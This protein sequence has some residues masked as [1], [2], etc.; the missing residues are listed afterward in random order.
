MKKDFI[1]QKNSEILEESMV[2]IV[3]AKMKVLSFTMRI[4]FAILLISILSSP[5]QT[6]A[7]T[8]QG[9]SNTNSLNSGLVGYWTFDGKNMTNATATDSSGNGNHG[10]LTNLTS[11]ST[12]FIGKIGKGIT[13]NGATGVSYVL[14]PYNASLDVATSGGA[15]AMWFKNYRSVETGDIVRTYYR[16]QYHPNT[17][18]TNGIHFGVG[19]VSGTNVPLKLR[20]MYGTGANVSVTAT[21]I[22]LLVNKWYHG[23]ATWDGTTVRLYLDGVEVATSSQTGV[24]SWGY[25]VGGAIGAS[26]SGSG[27]SLPCS[28]AVDDVRVYNRYI[29]S[30]EVQA[31]YKLGGGTSVAKPQTPA[32]QNIGIN[33]GLVGYWTFDGKNMTNAT[34]T[35]SS[36]NGNNGTLTNMTATSSKA[37]GKIGQALTFNGNTQ[38]VL[39]STSTTYNN[40]S[41]F[42]ISAWI[43]PQG[44]GGNNAG[45]IIDKTDNTTPSTGWSFQLNDPTNRRFQF[46]IACSS[47]GSI[48]RITSNQSLKLNTWTHV[49]AK[50]DGTTSSNSIRLYVNGVEEQSYFLSQ[51]CA[52]SKLSDSALSVSIGNNSTNVRG[53]QGVIDDLRIYNRQVSDAEIYSLYKAGGGSPVASSQSVSTKNLGINS[54]IVGHWTFDGKNMTNATATDSSG[55]GNHGTLNNMTQANSKTPGKIGQALKFDNTNDYISVPNFQIS[56]GALTICAWIKPNS[57]GGGSFGRI[58]TSSIENTNFLIDSTDRIAFTSDSSTILYSPTLTYRKWIHACAT[59]D[60]SGVTSYIYQ[61]G[62]QTASG[63]TGTPT[64]NGATTYLGGRGAGDRTF[65]GIIDDV[66]IYNR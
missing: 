21:N 26:I 32:T 59:R 25:N 53:F 48:R 3:R 38:A 47:G 9:V 45:R 14:V 16:W 28:C 56:T 52:T 55:N 20:F 58:V 33:S 7:L 36:G 10:T 30:Q 54:G 46:V 17:A 50:W 22:P 29:T 40:M 12:N 4:L 15:I 18:N 42:T 37:T 57:K 34:A 23:V 61:N 31:I 43:F 24:F 60:S 35:D 64:T 41:L 49:V 27:S 5:H 62:V 1:N 11:T 63:N 13:F 65:D 39:I 51:G 66:R 44:M 19:T 2:L 8:S 6:S